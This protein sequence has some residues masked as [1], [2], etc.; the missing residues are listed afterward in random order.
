VIEIYLFVNPLGGLCLQSEKEIMKIAASQKK[1]MHYR[2]IPVVNMKSIKEYLIREGVQHTD[3]E[4][5]NYFFETSYSAALDLKAIQ[6]Q[7][8]KLGRL[9]L[10]TIQQRV[11]IERHHYSKDLVLSIVEEIG[12]DAEMFQEDRQS[13]LVKRAFTTDQQLAHEMSVVA[14]PSAVLYDFD[15]DEDGMIIEQ[16]IIPTINEYLQHYRDEDILVP[17][18]D[19]VVHFKPK[20]KTQGNIQLLN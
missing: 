14:L 15:K 2:F 18:S 19:K 11:G 13:D 3:I 9:F 1:R 8:R 4:K 6:L 12:G 5:R 7:G 10:T 20:D 17:E 16:D